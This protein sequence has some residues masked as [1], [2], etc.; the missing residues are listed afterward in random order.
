M[1]SAQVVEQTWQ[2]V[3][4]TPFSEVAGL[5]DEM[6]REQPVMLAYLLA[7]DGLPF[8]RN[9]CEHILYIGMVAWQIMKQ[10]QRPLRQVT[11]N[12]LK[13]IEEVNYKFLERLA[14]GS[15]EDFVQNTDRML[16]DYAEPEVLRYLYEAITEESTDPYETPIRDEYQGL[17][18]VYLKTVLDAMIASQWMDA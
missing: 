12:R 4:Q 14:G 8:N 5:V 17:A 15:E 9:E 10:S 3:A 18:F 7:A 1:I 6:R 13:S 16:W 11:E 2:R